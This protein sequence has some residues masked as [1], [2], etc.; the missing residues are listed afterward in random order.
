MQGGLGAHCLFTAS[1]KG[2]SRWQVRPGTTL[3][4]ESTFALGGMIT[5]SSGRASRRS[6]VGAW[7]TDRGG[8]P[9]A[10]AARSAAARRADRAGAWSSRAAGRARPAR[11]WR[12][13]GRRYWVAPSLTLPPS[14][15]SA[16]PWDTA[17]QARL[18]SEDFFRR[19]RGRGGAATNGSARAPRPAL[20]ADALIY[21]PYIKRVF[22]VPLWIF[23]RK[24][25]YIRATLR[26][27]GRLVPL[28][29]VGNKGIRPSRQKSC[30]S[31]KLF[32]CPFISRFLF[33]DTRLPQRR[34]KY[35]TDLGKYRLQ[36]MHGKYKSH[37]WKITLCTKYI[38]GGC[39]GQ[40]PG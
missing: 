20:T 29:V 12:G 13:R 35:S 10:V 18:F 5:T 40:W 15:H 24:P 25:F 8:G 30:F 27:Y 11:A 36:Q 34:R 28:G 22:R 19:G 1:R 39:G 37:V 32:K 2:R 23:L 16:R 33:F 4:T 14:A 7:S 26:R 17:V 3:N 31:Q 9:G 21:V 6:E 38:S